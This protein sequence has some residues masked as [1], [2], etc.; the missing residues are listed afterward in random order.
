M[1]DSEEGRSAAQGELGD[2]LFSIVNAS[3]LY[4][5]N[6]DTALETTCNKFRRRFTFVEMEAR[7][8][9][10]DIKDLTLA[11]MDALWEEAKQSE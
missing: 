2:L 3:R 11:E 6:P 4:K 10:R 5:L 1:P 8:K 9:G 7:K